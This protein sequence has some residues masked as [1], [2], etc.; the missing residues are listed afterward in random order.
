[1]FIPM[2]CGSR[3][4]RI[5]KN[6]ENMTAIVMKSQSNKLHLAILDNLSNI[7]TDQPYATVNGLYKSM[8]EYSTISKWSL[9]E[10]PPTS[11]D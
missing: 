3:V 7:L 6:A 11:K 2:W 1:M 8:E 5:Y 10:S 9:V 4:L